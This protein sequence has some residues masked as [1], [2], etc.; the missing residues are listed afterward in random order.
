[1]YKGGNRIIPKTI[2][3]KDNVMFLGNIELSVPT[4]GNKIATGVTTIE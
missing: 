3:Q 2:S 1:L 4:V